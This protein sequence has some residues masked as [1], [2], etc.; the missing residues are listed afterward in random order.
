[1]RFRASLSA[2]V[3]YCG[4]AAAEVQQP[5]DRGP[6]P[7]HV[8]AMVGVVSVPRPVDVEAFVRLDEMFSIGAAYSDFPSAIAD[9]LLSLVGARSGSTNARLDDFS[10]LELD[11]RVMPWRGVLFLGA[12]F[13]R[14]A[15][16]GVVTDSG[17]TA[18]IDLTTWYATPR[19]GWLWTLGPGLLLGLDL[20]V[21][22]KLASTTSISVPPGS[23]SS[24]RNAVQALADLGASYPLPSVHF[25]IG[26]ML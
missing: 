19:L 16:R 17:R 6:A 9:P 21:Q 13:G 8:G 11:L 14:Q 2:A 20:G 26:W 23:S 7:F 1:M 5:A 12:S 15:L 18:A 4:A 25:R 24:V 10:S 22:L 3:L